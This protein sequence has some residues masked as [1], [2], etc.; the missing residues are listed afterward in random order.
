MECICLNGYL[1]TT[2]FGPTP[3]PS[4]WGVVLEVYYKKATI[5]NT[6]IY[7]QAKQAVKQLLNTHIIQRKMEMEKLENEMKQ[8]KFKKICVFCGSSPGKKSSYKEA[9]VE[10]GKELVSKNS[11]F[12][13]FC[14]QEWTY[15]CTNDS[16]SYNYN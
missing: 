2:T 6:N 7:T 5:S 3:P 12:S 16:I 13:I 11:L 15:C 1:H 4:V 8:S 9:A 14:V 10:L